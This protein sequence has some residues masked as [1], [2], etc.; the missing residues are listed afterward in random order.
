[1]ADEPIEGLMADDVRSLF[2]ATIK[3]IE[4]HSSL[5][6]SRQKRFRHGS[7][8]NG[9]PSHLSSLWVRVSQTAAQ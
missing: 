5:T 3:T 2:R 6:A 7:S 1:M 8:V 4:R 9:V